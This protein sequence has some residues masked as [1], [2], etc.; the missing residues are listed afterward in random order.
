V[1]VLYEAVPLDTFFIII[2]I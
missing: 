2:Q 1:D